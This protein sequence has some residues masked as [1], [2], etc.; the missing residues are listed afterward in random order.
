M[1]TLA[2]LVCSHNDSQLLASTNS[3]AYTYQRG[4]HAAL[5]VCS[6]GVEIFPSKYSLMDLRFI[7]P[8][9]FQYVYF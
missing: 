1:K 2:Y 5:T 6:A 7:S 9:S 3:S 8:H 4:C